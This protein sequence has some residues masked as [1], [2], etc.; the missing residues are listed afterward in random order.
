MATSPD[1]GDPDAHR[2]IAAR[3]VSS[4]WVTANCAAPAV[5]AIAIVPLRAT[6]LVAA[7]DAA[8]DLYVTGA[9]AATH[10]DASV[11]PQPVRIDSNVTLGPIDGYLKYFTPIRNRE[12]DVESRVCA[13]NADDTSPSGC[14]NVNSVGF[15]MPAAVTDASTSRPP[16]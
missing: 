16:K 10:R 14:A 1:E 8:R 13:A 11:R 5:Q 3:R 7:R 6:S 2:H 12:L 9:V 15:T 4:A